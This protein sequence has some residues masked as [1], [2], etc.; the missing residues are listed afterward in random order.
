MQKCEKLK[1]K[2]NGDQLLAELISRPARLDVTWQQQQQLRFHFL[3][4]FAFRFTPKLDETFLF[5]LHF[6]FI[7]FFLLL[8]IFRLPWNR[9]YMYISFTLTIRTSPCDAYFP[10]LFFIFILNFLTRKKENSSLLID[11]TNKNMKNVN[12]NVFP[13]EKRRDIASVAS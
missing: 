3:F 9:C 1:R 12:V 8:W 5:S 2:K 7:F 11:D 13:V 10:Q 6:Y 4:F